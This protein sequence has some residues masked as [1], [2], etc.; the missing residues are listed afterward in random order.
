MCLASQLLCFFDCFGRGGS[1]LF[2]LATITHELG[3]RLVC[4]TP[5]SGTEIAMDP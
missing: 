5:L 1:V 2:Y 3:M 4:F